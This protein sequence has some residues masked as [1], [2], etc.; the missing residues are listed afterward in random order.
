MRVWTQM[1]HFAGI[2]ALVAA[3]LFLKFGPL[4]GVGVDIN[5]H[6]RYRV[7]PISVIGFWFVAGIA[8]AWLLLVAARKLRHHSE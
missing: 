2:A 7:I 8:L 4:G 5:I 1:K 6:D 3:A